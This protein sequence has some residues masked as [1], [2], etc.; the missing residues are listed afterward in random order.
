MKNLFARF[1]RE[2]KGQDLIEYAL[3]AGLIS[4]VAVAAVTTVGTSITG[5]F[6]KVSTKLNA[7]TIP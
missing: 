7:V 1:V 2:E 4:L 5:L 6:G 3:L